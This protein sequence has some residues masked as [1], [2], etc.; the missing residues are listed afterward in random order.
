MKKEIICFVLGVL[1]AIGITAL[2]AQMEVNPNAF[3]VLVDGQ[4]VSIEGYN[5]N[6]YTY[7]KLRDIGNSIGFDV[8]FKD[9]TIA[10]NTSGGKEQEKPVTPE[11]AYEEMKVRLDEKVKAGEMT[12][13][14]A[15]EMLERFTNYKE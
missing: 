4:P 13:S 5:L 7:F 10:I 6:G 3:P 1:T 14:E 11:E 15:D 9:N 2:A 8:E 12:Q